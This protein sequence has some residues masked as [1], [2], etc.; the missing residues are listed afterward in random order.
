MLHFNFNKISKPSRRLGPGFSDSWMSIGWH[1]G[2]RISWTARAAVR[3]AKASSCQRIP[4]SPLLEA[5]VR[6]MWRT[7][8]FTSSERVT[9]LSHALWGGAFGLRVPDPQC[10]SR[11]LSQQMKC[12]LTLHTSPC[13]GPELH[14]YPTTSPPHA[15]GEEQV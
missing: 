7:G 4:P 8:K 9:S 3:G 2:Y 1:S 11:P 15:P 12:A 13:G 14:V 5:C 6:L 10:L